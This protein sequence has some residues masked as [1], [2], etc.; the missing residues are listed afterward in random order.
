MRIWLDRNR[1][2]PSLFEVTFLPGREVRFRL[3]FGDAGD[4][5]AVAHAF[6]GQL[7]TQPETATTLAA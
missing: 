7:L 2:E 6:G 4:A 1:K 5:S 3:L